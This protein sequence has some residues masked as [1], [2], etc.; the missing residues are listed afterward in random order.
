MSFPERYEKGLMVE[1][2]A[3]DQ[4][5]DSTPSHPLVQNVSVSHGLDSKHGSHQQ[6]SYDL[7]RLQQRDIVRHSLPLRSLPSKKLP[8]SSAFTPL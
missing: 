5:T 2:V 3:I 4:E 8:R 6:I 7:E 1:T